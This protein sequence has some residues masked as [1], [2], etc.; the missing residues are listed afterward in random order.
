M[1]SFLCTITFLAG[2]ICSG[3]ELSLDSAITLALRHEGFRDSRALLADMKAL[4]ADEVNSAW[5]PQFN[6]N[7]QST[8]QN[9]QIDLPFGLPG[10]AP[11][12]VPLDLHRALIEIGQTVYDGQVTRSR[13]RLEQL[14]VDQQ[15]L[16][17]A[18]RELEVR[19]Q[20]T[21]RYMAVLL[22]ERQLGL[23]ALRK[24]S[25]LAQHERL[26]AAV[27]AGAALLSDAAALEAETITLDQEIAQ[28]STTVKRTRHELATIT[29]AAAVATASFVAP[30][31][32]EPGDLS[33]EQRPDIRAFDLRLQALDVQ[34]DLAR[35]SRLPRIRVFGNA[36]AGNPGYNTFL[37]EWRPM[38]LV[39]AGIQWRIVDWGTRKRTDRNIDLQRDLLRMDRE[40]IVE[41]WTIA[42]AHQRE[43]LAHFR[44]LR[45]SDDRLIALRTEVTEAKAEQ[46][47]NGTATA[48]DYVNEL[49][50]EHAARLGREIHEL[51]AVLAIRTSKDIQAR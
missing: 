33:V 39:G 5:F 10:L 1:R 30:V 32:T 50:K 9:E 28:V 48:A 45:S 41:R 24:A 13:L 21:Q 20:V 18:S 14:D 17:L 8:Y 40:R 6:L 19:G 12:E 23:L 11:P 25:I 51:Q 15:D 46:L 22:G 44:A 47:A 27:D 3:Q 49:N 36:G 4:Q 43:E 34:H 42:L 2:C 37:D 16:A 26:I 7:V 35:S 38:L 29:D 31:E